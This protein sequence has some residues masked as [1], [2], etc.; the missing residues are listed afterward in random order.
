MLEPRQAL[1]QWGAKHLNKSVDEI[2]I[3]EVNKVVSTPA[4]MLAKNIVE[5]EIGISK[6]CQA[7]IDMA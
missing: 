2:H 7:L 3:D 5:A 1:R 4:Y 6:L